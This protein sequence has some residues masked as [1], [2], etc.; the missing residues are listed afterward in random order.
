VAQDD[1]YAAGTEPLRDARTHY[2]G[3]NHSRV[4]NLF[5]RHSGRSLL[6]FLC[7]EE[8]ANQV[9]RRFRLAKIHNPVQ[10]QAQRFIGRNRQ[11]FIDDFASAFKSWVPALSWEAELLRRRA[12]T[13]LPLH[14]AFACTQLLACVVE[15]LVLRHDV[16]HETELQGLLSGIKSSLQNHFSSLGSA[17]QSRQASAATPGGN[18]PQR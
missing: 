12:R 8:I 4:H 15:K 6:V 7:Q 3:S 11:S 14:L 16:I 10:F 2:T 17:N 5:R 1:G 13:S 9:L 18:K